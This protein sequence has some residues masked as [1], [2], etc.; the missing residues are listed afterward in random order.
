MSLIRQFCTFKFCK[1]TSI[2]CFCACKN[3]S[4][5]KFY[6]TTFYVKYMRIIMSSHWP[7][8]CSLRGKIVKDVEINKV[9]SLI[10]TALAHDNTAWSSST[11]A[12]KA[13]ITLWGNWQVP[14]GEMMAIKGIKRAKVWGHQYLATISSLPCLVSTLLFDVSLLLG[15][16]H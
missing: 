11:T 10:A 16:Q 9:I 6:R 13:I 2:V 8:P 14:C 7:E 15:S 1:Y 4:K 12:R 3:V 5:C